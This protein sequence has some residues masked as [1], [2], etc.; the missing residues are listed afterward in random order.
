MNLFYHLLYPG[1]PHRGAGIGEVKE[2]IGPFP[3][4]VGAHG[5]VLGVL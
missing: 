1:K 3:Q 5:E 4:P 2:Y